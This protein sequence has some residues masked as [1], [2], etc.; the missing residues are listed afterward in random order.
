MICNQQGPIVSRTTRMISIGSGFG[1]L[2]FRIQG[3]SVGF[4]IIL[5]LGH[6]A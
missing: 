4:R 3:E 2:G 6:R 5:G 1:G